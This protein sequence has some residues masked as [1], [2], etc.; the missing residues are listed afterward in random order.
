M[1]TIK[2]I[3]VLLAASAAMALGADSNRTVS[4]A[5]YSEKRFY[6]AVW[7]GPGSG[8]E[9]DQ[10]ARLAKLAEAG[11]TDLLPEDGPKRLKELIRLGKPLGIRIHAWHWM[12]NVG[13][14]KECQ[15]HPEWYS[16][17]RLGQ[18]CRDFH[19]YVGYYNFLSP[20]SPGARDY[21]K[22]GV[23]EIAQ[24]KGLASVHFDY[25]RYVDVILGSELQTHYQHNGGPLVQDRLMAEYDFGYH[26]L[27]RKEFKEK[28]GVDPMN[29]S[30]KEENAAW[31]QFRMDAITS[32]VNE[33]VD[34]CHEEGALASAAVFPFPE[35]AREYVR[36]DWG[37]WNLDLF[38]PMAYKKDHGGNVYWVGFATKQGVRDLKPGQRL[39]TGVLVDHYGDNLAEFEQA[40]RQ[41]QDNGANGIAFFTAGSLKDAH[42]ALI[43]KYNE[44]FNSNRHP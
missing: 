29:L 5:S 2:V 19:P 14:A 40:I 17:N 35:L 42:L 13:G 8:T 15:E 32:L 23:R 30:D 11:I 26:P 21:I 36:Q 24:V 25:I 38:F 34:I 1:R 28:F 27:A 18:S 33:C 37:H 31:K 39:F 43:K 41:A 4:G 10:Q 16:V 12:M 7:G 3:A 6:F 22:K 9:V 44:A 20:F